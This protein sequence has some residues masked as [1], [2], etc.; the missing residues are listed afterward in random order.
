MKIDTDIII[1]DLDGTLVDSSEDIAW[2]ANKTL[3]DMGYEPRG[4][5]EI[6]ASIGW[7]IHHLM[8]QLIP[9]AGEKELLTAREYFLKHYGN[10]IHVDTR[11]FDGVE[12]TINGF[13][14]K[15]IKLAIATNKPI[16]LTEEL[17]KSMGERDKFDV[18][19]GGDSVER[20]KPHPEPVHKILDALGG[21]PGKTVFV[22]DSPVDCHSARAG[23]AHSVGAVYGFRGREELV[24]AE[25]DYLIDSFSELDDI[26]D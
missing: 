4:F 8:K 15:G 3:E 5:E 11:Y 19:L 23:G 10:H 20:K 18:V 12:K 25:A 2:S 17:L 1:F 26:I 13:I 9:H 22:G 21:D 7:G 16:A 24:K 6:K 14:E